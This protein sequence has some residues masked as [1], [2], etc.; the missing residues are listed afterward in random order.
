VIPG[1]RRLALTRLTRDESAIHT[2]AGERAGVVW[3]RAIMTVK[4]IMSVSPETCTP[5]TTLATRKVSTC[6]SDDDVED[7]V[8]TM[9]HARVRRLPVV[10]ANRTLIGIL[11]LNDI[12]LAAG[13]NKPV[14]DRDVVDGLQGICAHRHGS[15]ADAAA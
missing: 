9:K 11:S 13:D 10:D 6:G 8:A 14:R 2:E 7:A 12:V 1:H 5:D 3:E 4:E 15:T